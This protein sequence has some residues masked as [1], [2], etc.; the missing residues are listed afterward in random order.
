MAVVN[1]GWTAKA[2]FSPIIP[3]SRAVRWCISM[4]PVHYVDLG[5]DGTLKIDGRDGT[6][7]LVASKTMENQLGQ[8]KRTLQQSRDSHG[9]FHQITSYLVILWPR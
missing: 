4:L 8:S 2:G 1:V 5:L 9:G 7:T 3:N 6:D